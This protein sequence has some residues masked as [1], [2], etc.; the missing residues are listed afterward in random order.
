MNFSSLVIKGQI[1]KVLVKE[2]QGKTSYSCQFLT[3]DDKQGFKVIPVK[4]EQ[5]FLGNVKDGD[6]VEAPIKITTMNG[7]IYYSS[8]NNIKI[9][10]Q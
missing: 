4:V 10:K 7:N 6:I 1:V 9:I 2:Y 3:Q 5:E 8:I